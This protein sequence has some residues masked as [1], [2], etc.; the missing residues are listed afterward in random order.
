MNLWAPMGSK[1]TILLGSHFY[2]TEL[3]KCS[4]SHR[5]YMCGALVQRLG[6]WTPGQGV[7]PA[8]DRPP[9]S[10]PKNI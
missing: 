8:G 4:A 3:I 2:V 6:R 7:L 9:N 5:S 10:E 1:H